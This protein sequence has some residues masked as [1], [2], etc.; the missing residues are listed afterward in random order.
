MNRAIVL[1]LAVGLLIA[2]GISLL[3]LSPEDPGTGGANGSSTT[4][5]E[6]DAGDRAD[7]GAGESSEAGE[8]GERPRHRER[9][10]GATGE[11]DGPRRLSGVVQSSAGDALTGIA[12]EVYAVPESYEAP[13]DSV[14]SV[15]ET[16]QERVT[17]G[18]EAGDQEVAI[19]VGTEIGME[20]LADGSLGDLL[21]LATS[22]GGFAEDT[23]WP[24]AG[25]SNTDGEGRFVIDLAPAERYELRIDVVGFQAVRR[26]VAPG[27]DVELRLMPGAHLRGTIRGPNGPIAGAKVRTSLRILTTDSAGE[28]HDTGA[29]VGR[30]RILVEAPGHVAAA[31]AVETSLGG[32]PAVV[33]IELEGA[34]AFEGVVRT[35]SGEP[36][37]GATVRTVTQFNPMDFMR[38]ANR[39]GG[40]LTAPPPTA[41]TDRDGHYRLDGVPAGAVDLVAEAPEYVEARRIGLEARIGETVRGVDFELLGEASLVGV[42]RDRQGGTVAGARVSV[43]L[44][45]PEGARGMAAMMAQFARRSVT[46]VS[47]GDGSYTVTGLPPG[48]LDVTVSSAGYRSARATIQVEAEGRSEHDF[49]LDPGL[50][51]AG[52]VLDPAGAPVPG[53]EV[54]IDWPDLDENP[55]AAAMAAFAGFNGELE[56]ETD[57]EGVWRATGLEEGPYKIQARA[58]GFLDVTIDEIP[59][60]EQE[61]VLQLRAA[62]SVSG[63]V[64]AQDGSGPVAPAEVIRTGGPGGGGMMAMFS[65]GTESEDVAADG[66]FEVGGLEPGRYTFWA[67]AKGYAEGEQIKLELSEGQVVTGIQLALP[68]GQSLT[69]RVVRKG[70]GAPVAG[71]L[72]Y[73]NLG[74]GMA[75]GAMDA[76]GVDMAPPESVSTRSDQDGYFTL[77]G[78]TPGRRR[79][80]A[81]SEGLATTTVTQQVPGAGIII[82]LGV[83]GTVRGR[84]LDDE[85]NPQSG[86]QVL[87]MRGMM[88]LAGQ[89]STDAQGYYEMTTL[90]PGRYSLMLMDPESPMGMGATTAVTVADGEVVVHDFGKSPDG[91]TMGGAV[92]RDGE[93]ASGLNVVLMGGP[94]GMKMTQTGRDGRFRFEDLEPGTYQVMVQSGPMSGGTASREVTVAEDG[95]VEDVRLELSSLQ[96]SGRVV[97]AT[98][99]QP[100]NGAQVLLLVSGSGAAGSMADLAAQNKG[101]GFTLDDGSFVLDGVEPGTFELRAMKAGYAQAVVEG[102]AAGTEGVVVR[103]TQ[104]REV[105]V[106]VLDPAGNPLP[107]ASISVRDAQGRESYAFDMSMSGMTGPD[108]MARLR[109]GAGRHE[110]TASADGYPATTAAAPEG[111]EAITIQLVAGGELQVRVVDADGEPVVGADVKVYDADGAEIR[112][113]LSFGSVFSAGSQTDATGVASRRGLPTGAVTVRVRRGNGPTASV[114]TEILAN[115]TTE[116]D[117]VLD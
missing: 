88:Q 22:G 117:V 59:T 48:A 62:A 37:P 34:G 47:R 8:S 85:G 24:L 17:E 72:V 57:A 103:M 46:G 112:E 105:E 98:T 42:V 93:P 39:G 109:L 79:I 99:G 10:D 50:T 97:D 84:V 114:T 27:D 19:E 90:T 101:Q 107:N 38:L 33:V 18:I 77:D 36:V 102:V 74:Q 86:A 53:A 80:V 29:A 78:L 5:D 110:L 21:N 23:N 20:A 68:P 92:L 67:R 3:V 55:M 15:V 69:G 32:E 14:R 54:E 2:A 52:L 63:V 61:V 35:S 30:E 1:F 51:L 64:V 76:M 106:T 108:G 31:R 58:D 87:L 70:D 49:T 7:V 71:A 25:G 116:V 26:A 115:G 4:A 82:E 95:V 100:V 113:R 43:A 89:S 12:V 28:F 81:R 16:L 65:G 6:T 44:P 73:V 11:D 111:A 91:K 60:G 56:V 104:G 66:T 96:V 94:G 75:A 9:R 45:A 13:A 40:D 41:V 83:G